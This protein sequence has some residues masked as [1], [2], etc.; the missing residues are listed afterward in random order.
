PWGQTT[1]VTATVTGAHGE[2][3]QFIPVRFTVASGGTPTPTNGAGTTNASGQAA[4]SYSN[5]TAG[6]DTVTVW[7]DLDEDT[8]QD[9]G[10]TTTVTV[11]WSK[12][13]TSIAYT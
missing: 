11:V 1:T 3:E 7:A 10:E 9:A 5:G 6:S 2:A 12:H 8:T 13:P 4:F